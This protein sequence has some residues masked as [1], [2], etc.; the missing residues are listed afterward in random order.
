[1]FTGD[2]HLIYLGGFYHK[3]KDGQ[4]DFIIMTKSPVDPVAEIHNRMPVIIPK[5]NTSDWLYNTDDAIRLMRNNLVN[6]K[7]ERIS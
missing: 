3:D 7:R 4:E 2:S 1:M 6:L 5:A